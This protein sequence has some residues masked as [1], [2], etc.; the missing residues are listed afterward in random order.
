MKVQT[1]EQVG[2]D[3]GKQFAY[4]LHRVVDR[5]DICDDCCF[6]ALAHEI[7]RAICT[8]FGAHPYEAI[9]RIEALRSKLLSELE[10]YRN[11]GVISK[12]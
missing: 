11:T 8:A 5:A 6:D 12:L 9:G 1:A 4:D 7:S 3:H 10:A 2:H